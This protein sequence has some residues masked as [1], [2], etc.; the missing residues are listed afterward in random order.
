[1]SVLLEILTYKTENK[2][3]KK[4]TLLLFVAL[5]VQSIQS[6]NST[7][8]SPQINMVITEEEAVAVRGKPVGCH[9]LINSS[10]QR[11]TIRIG[12]E[13]FS[14]DPKGFLYPKAKEV[15]SISIN[16]IAV[17]TAPSK[18]CF[19]FI[20]IKE[21]KKNQGSIEIQ[22]QYLQDNDPDAKITVFDPPNRV[23]VTMLNRQ[24][25]AG[26]KS[27]VKQRAAAARVRAAAAAAAAALVPTPAPQPTRQKCCAQCG[28]E[29][30]EGTKLKMC[31]R[32][33]QARYCSETCQT[34][35]WPQHKLSCN[36]KNQKNCRAVVKK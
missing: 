24:Q 6:A 29:K 18:G 7:S 11:I 27:S 32:C 14:I 4:L 17:D 8:T 34:T 23:S 19:A 36:P 33:R 1:M 20:T 35:D 25:S 21:S 15:R 13:E 31:G 2:P 22:G 16:S 9:C 28:Q 30:P 26:T 12:K 3:M 10:Q 5:A